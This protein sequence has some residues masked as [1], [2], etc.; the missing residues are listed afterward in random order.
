MDDF[1]AYE[2]ALI[3]TILCDPAAYDAA[4]DVVP[5]DMLSPQHRLI[6]SKAA[7]LARRGGLGMQSLCIALGDDLN[8]VGFGD[9][10]GRDYIGYLMSMGD[11]ATVDEFARQVKNASDLRRIIEISSLVMAKARSGGDA[12]EIIDY[13]TKEA[14]AMRR[15]KREPVFLGSLTGDYNNRSAR[16]RSG[17]AVPF[18]EPPLLALKN[19]IKYMEDV[20]FALLVGSPA[21]GKSSLLRYL[22]LETAMRGSWVLTLPF[23]NSAEEYHSWAISQIARIDHYHVVDPRLQEPGEAEEIEEAA[24]NLETYPYLIQEMGIA[25]IN[26]VIAAIRRTKLKHDLGLVLIDGLYLI[27]SDKEQYAAISKHTQ[28]LR[29]LAQEI[30]VPIIATTQFNRGVKHKKEPEQEDVLFAGENPA[31][32]MWA[33]RRQEMSPI[34]AGRF[35]LNRD[36]KGK[37][38]LSDSLRSVVVR[39]KVL[40]N[41]GGSGGTTEPIAWHKP[42]NVYETLEPNWNSS[43]PDEAGG[44][45]EPGSSFRPAPKP[46]REPKKPRW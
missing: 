7:D 19:L 41:T 32:K 24:A 10:R 37:V 4:A 29:S 28:M 43:E 25:G 21:T 33:I 16:I 18:W 3:G 36:K 13:Y 6:W 11:S 34:E 27:H 2:Q 20:D 12:A 39:V 44:A 9:V 35:P 1:N 22:G 42:W 14:L 45:V 38:M 23:E 46:E 31:R 17:E 15:Q 26:D 40:K 30:H 8:S 5:G